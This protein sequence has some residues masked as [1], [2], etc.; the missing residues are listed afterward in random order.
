VEAEVL[1]NLKLHPIDFSQ[2]PRNRQAKVG[3][4][5]LGDSEM[6]DLFLEVADSLKHGV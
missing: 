3:W 2:K 6:R 5:C 1:A 4:I